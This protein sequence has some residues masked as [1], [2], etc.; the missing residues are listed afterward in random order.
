V[1]FGSRPPVNA[2]RSDLLAGDRAHR[3]L[4]FGPSAHRQSARLA[5]TLSTASLADRYDY[6]D[7]E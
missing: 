1:T 2:G 3:S 6:G 4:Q 5:S 7:D